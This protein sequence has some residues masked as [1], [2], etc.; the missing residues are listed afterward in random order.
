MRSVLG[1]L[2][3][4]LSVV[5]GLYVGGWIFFIGGIVDVISAVKAEVTIPLDLALGIG[6]VVF[7]S[8]AGTASA[9]LLAAPGYAMMNWGD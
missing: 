4:V 8:L 3:I 2:M 7:S 1:F 6:K 5:L 9:V